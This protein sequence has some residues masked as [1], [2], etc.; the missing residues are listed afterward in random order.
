MKGTE[1]MVVVG[2]NG[3]LYVWSAGVGGHIQMWH[4]DL[5]AGVASDLLDLPTRNLFDG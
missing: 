3:C 4:T 5:V 1:A 2:D